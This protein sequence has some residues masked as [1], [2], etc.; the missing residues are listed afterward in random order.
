M[1]QKWTGRGGT[2]GA[3][4]GPVSGVSLAAVSHLILMEEKARPPVSSY[5]FHSVQSC[6]A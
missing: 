1:R 3:V 5:R 4:L 2:S 6:A